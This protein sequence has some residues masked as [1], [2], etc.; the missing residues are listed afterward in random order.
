MSTTCLTSDILELIIRDFFSMETFKGKDSMF[1]YQYFLRLGRQMAS[2][3]GQVF[4][5]QAVLQVS[6]LGVGAD[7]LLAA[8][9]VIA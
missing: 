3:T 1:C 4:E 8:T 7:R 5:R 6:D 9:T 2:R